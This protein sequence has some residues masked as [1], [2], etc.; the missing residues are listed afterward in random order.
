MHDQPV[1]N[2]DGRVV[3]V[4]CQ[5]D[6]KDV[7]VKGTRGVVLR[8]GAYTSNSKLIGM[9][10]EQWGGVSSCTRPTSTGDGVVLRAK[11]VEVLNNLTPEDTTEIFEAIPGLFAGGEIVEWSCYT[12]SIARVFMSSSAPCWMDLHTISPW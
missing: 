12:S 10:A 2:E 6:G 3:G 5:Q 4:R 9:F 11:G 7:Y 8:T 1:T